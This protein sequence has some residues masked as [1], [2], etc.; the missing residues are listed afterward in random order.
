MGK[1]KIEMINLQEI[2]PYKLNLDTGQVYDSQ[3]QLV[4]KQNTDIGIPHEDFTKQVSDL[5]K[6]GTPIEKIHQAIDGHEQI[7]DKNTAKQMAT[8]ILKNVSQPLKVE[9]S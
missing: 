6:K 5:A 1:R 8:E 3:G 9:K 7:T 4:V 2:Q